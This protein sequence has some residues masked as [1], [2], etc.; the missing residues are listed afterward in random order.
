MEQ[1]L[2]VSLVLGGV[3]FFMG[4]VPS[5]HFI[6]QIL[7]EYKNINVELVLSQYVPWVS[8][9]ACGF[10]V[11]FLLITDILRYKLV[12][13]ISTAAGACYFGS[14]LW[15]LNEDTILV[16]FL[17]LTLWYFNHTKYHHLF[18]VQL[19]TFFSGL[20]I[21][22]DIAY[23]TYIY[24]KVER[25]R[26]QQVTS[27]TRSAILVGRCLGAITSQLFVLYNV[28]NPLQMVYISFASKC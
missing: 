26:Y 17:Y 23:F 7:T 11:V 21:A 9:W 8:Y 14:Q 10:L 27:N 22:T 5:Q 28:L 13:V 24:A 16:S 18:S 20:H 15:T 12:I 2:R 4:M 3:G 19:T 6:F 1:W 25:D